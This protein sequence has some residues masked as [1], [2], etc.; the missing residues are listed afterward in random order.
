MGSL[1]GPDLVIP[2]WSQSCIYMSWERVVAPGHPGRAQTLWPEPRPG[3]EL[4][5]RLLPWVWCC[6]SLARASSTVL[7][8]SPGKQSRALM[9]QVSRGQE[10]A[11]L[12]GPLQPAVLSRGALSD[13]LTLTLPYLG[14]PQISNFLYLN[15]V[16]PCVILLC[17]MKTERAEVVGG[18]E[19]PRI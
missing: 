5:S 4:T 11:G 6:R 17:K 19:R 15:I 16:L 1:P 12:G 8:G 7:P 14:K 13:E 9:N 10:G 18:G 3:A 2:L